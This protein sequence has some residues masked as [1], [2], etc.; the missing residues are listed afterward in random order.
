MKKSRYDLEQVDFCLRH[1]EE[2]IPVVAI[3]RNMGIS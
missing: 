1:A 2:G 3:C